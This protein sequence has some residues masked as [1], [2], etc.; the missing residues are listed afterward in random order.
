MLEIKRIS[1]LFL[2][3]LFEFTGIYPII[4]QI[5]LKNRTNDFPDSGFTFN[6]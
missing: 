1:A 3:I 5:T 2:M 6:F 4:Q